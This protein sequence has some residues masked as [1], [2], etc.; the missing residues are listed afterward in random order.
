MWPPASGWEH[1]RHAWPLAA[2]MEQ[3]YNQLL[4]KLRGLA[5]S[6]TCATQSY[7][8]EAVYNQGALRARL[9]KGLSAFLGDQCISVVAAFLA[10]DYVTKPI[11]F[12]VRPDSLAIDGRASRRLPKARSKRP[13]YA[14]RGGI[15]SFAV[16]SAKPHKNKVVV[17]LALRE[18]A[19][20]SIQKHT[21]A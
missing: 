1:V 10:E 2:E 6:L 21:L 20:N 7:Y 5:G 4:A 19:S 12:H 18:D 16:L 8:V 3:Q 13:E 9:G 14:F 17:W 11:A 15:G